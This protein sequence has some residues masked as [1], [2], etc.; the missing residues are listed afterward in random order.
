MRVAASIRRCSLLAAA[1]ATASGLAFVAPARAA[2]RKKESAPVDIDDLFGAPP[3]K[4]ASLDA[5]KEAAES[6]GVRTGA[7][8]LAP[9][10]G[11]ID[12]DAP[13]TFTGVFAATA[14]EQHKKL[15]CQPAGRDKMKITTWTLDEVPARAPQGFEVC[16]SLQSAAGREMNMSLAIVDNR[17]QRVARAEDV[18]NFRGHTKVDHVLQYPAPLFKLA[19]PYFYVIDLDGKEAARLPLFTV[20]VAGYT[21]GLPGSALPEGASSQG[22][23]ADPLGL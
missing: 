14:I 18:I 20:V 23:A 6:V 16:V 22:S 5:M 7:D 17:N 12:N 1:C 11:A 2:E 3:V 10:S 4:P 8:G 9:R 15:G 13:V 21:S 19:G